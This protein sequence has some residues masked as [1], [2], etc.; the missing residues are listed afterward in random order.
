MA[1]GPVLLLGLLCGAS[2][3]PVDVGEPLYITPLIRAGKLEEAR[4]K[5]RVVGAPDGPDMGEAGFLT[6]DEETG[7][8]MFYWYFEAQ[9]GNKQAPLL[10]WLQGGPGGSSLFGLFSEM[11]P[12]ALDPLLHLVARNSTW[13]KDYAMLF[14][15]NPVGA[16]FSHTTDPEGYCKDT[17]Q[18]VASNLYS[19]LK[20]FYQLHAELQSLPLYITGESYGGHYVPGIGAYIVRENQ[21]AGSDSGFVIPLAGI[22]VGDGWIDPVKQIAAYP[23]MMFGQGMISLAQR[24]TIQSYCDRAIEKIL[25]NDM[26][27]AFDVW[28]KM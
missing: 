13:N 6:T 1:T 3:L 12:F 9:S 24:A 15:D 26:T 14:I 28:D 5:S 25:V 16:G 17:K 19:L 27:G 10:V 18:C 11:G 8:N 23:E 22:A 2:A 21:K 20:Q 7:K 4:H